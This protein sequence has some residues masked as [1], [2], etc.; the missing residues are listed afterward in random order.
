MPLP[1]YLQPI[2]VLNDNDDRVGQ[3]VMVDGQLAAVLVRLDGEEH[4]D[5]LRGKWFL[6]AGFGRCSEAR[7]PVF[8]DLGEAEVWVQHKLAGSR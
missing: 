6:E 7:P 2:R 4:G 8:A 1:I 3:L 5:D